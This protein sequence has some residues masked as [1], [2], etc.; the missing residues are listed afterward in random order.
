MNRILALFGKND[1]EHESRPAVPKRGG[2][3][4]AGKKM[5][6]AANVLMFFASI[7]QRRR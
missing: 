1:L 3:D 7:L 4:C 5:I 2:D 6:C